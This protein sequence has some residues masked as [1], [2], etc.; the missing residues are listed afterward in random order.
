MTPNQAFQRTDSPRFARLA[1]AERRRYMHKGVAMLR[2]LAVLMAVSSS[3]VA[4]D[5]CAAYSKA[6][7]AYLAKA[8]I[9]A[10]GVTVRG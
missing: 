5:D 7:R 10:A 2:Y 8:A 4:A 6:V 9:E 3:A 1:A